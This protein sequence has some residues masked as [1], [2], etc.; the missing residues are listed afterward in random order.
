MT[1]AMFE[2][3]NFTVCSVNN[4]PLYSG[5]PDM[6]YVEGDETK[7]KLSKTK[8]LKLAKPFVEI[9][10]YGGLTMR[11]Y[12]SKIAYHGADSG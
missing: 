4:C 11:E 7:C 5:Y 10:K 1:G 2:C 8:R 3:P 12:S 9:L 6:S